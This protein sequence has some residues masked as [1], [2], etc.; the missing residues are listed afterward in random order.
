MV[1]F[2]DFLAVKHFVAELLGT[3]LLTIMA[4]GTAIN[5]AYNWGLVGPAASPVVRNFVGHLAAGMGVMMGILITG[6]ASGGHINPAVSVAMVVGKKMKAVLLPAYLLGQYIGATAGSL[7]VLGLYADSLM[8]GG[9]MAESMNG[10]PVLAS[11]YASIVFDQITASFL[12]LILII[13]VVEQGH[14]PGGLLV[15]LSVAGIGMCLGPN[16]G[17]SMNPAVDLMPRLMAAIWEGRFLS[18]N[19]FAI[20]LLVPHVGGILGILVYEFCIL[21]LRDYE[22]STDEDSAKEAVVSEESEEKP[23]V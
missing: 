3:F 23:S 11:N 6:G 4:K 14:E 22:V 20:P 18:V 1:A 19:F 21:K 2:R 8:K 15:G 12:L 7:V 16:A 13:S 10:S 17:S 9:V 5:L